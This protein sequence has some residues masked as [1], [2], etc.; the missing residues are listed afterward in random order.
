LIANAEGTTT[1]RLGRPVG[2]FL[3]AEFAK[4]Y[5]NFSWIE[6]RSLM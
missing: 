5:C 2:F 4:T 3:C 1:H 6:V